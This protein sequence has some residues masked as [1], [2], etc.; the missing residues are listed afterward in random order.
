MK[1]QIVEMSRAAR[2][3]SWDLSVLTTN[4]KNR[5]LLSVVELLDSK[6]DFIKS[7]NKR[8][9]LAAEKNGLSDAM[10]DRLT[11]SDSV[12]DGMISGVKQIV[13]LPDPIGQTSNSSIRPNGLSVARMRIPI[14]VVA[15][16][17]ESR[18][19]VTIDAAALCLK[20]GNAT[21]LKGGSEALYSNVAL[22]QLFRDALIENGV[23]K[24]SMQVIADTNREV[25]GELIKQDEFID[26]VIPRG[27]EGLIRFVNDN[28]TIPVLKHYKGVCHLFIDKDADL[29]KINPIIVNAKTHRP[30]VCNALE[31]VL[32]HKDIA[33]SCIPSLVAALH[34]KNVEIKACERTKNIANGVMIASDDDWGTEFL[35]LAL[36]MKVVDSLAEARGY[37]QKYGS[38]HT[39]GIITESYSRARHFIASVDASAIVVNASTRFNDG[40]ELGL[41]AEIG[42]STSKLHAYGPMGLEELTAK[43]FVIQGEGQVRA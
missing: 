21:I 40:G 19:N 25:V 18:P 24:D 17:Y 20:S 32:I 15:M 37:I 11:L 39:E 22:A 7:E 26:M 34:E 13:S 33:Q 2:T 16:I 30:G 1:D 29:E 23:N 27:G 8:D 12:I 38:C 31:G 3:A 41:G 36:C 6:R 28:A 42:I 14:G 5:V 35:S 43:K 4:Q 9:V 10:I